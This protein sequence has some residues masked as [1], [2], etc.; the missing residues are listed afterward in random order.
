MLIWSRVCE[1]SRI[2]IVSPIQHLPSIVTI[3]VLGRYRLIVSNLAPTKNVSSWC[4]HLTIH[5]ARYINYLWNC[6]FRTIQP[7]RT[8]ANKLCYY[9]RELAC[10]RWT[11]RRRRR[12]QRQTG[13]N[14]PARVRWL[15][16]QFIFHW[17]RSWWVSWGCCETIFYHFL[18]TQTSLAQL[19][20]ECLRLREYLE[21]TIIVANVILYLWFPRGSTGDWRPLVT[22]KRTVN[23]NAVLI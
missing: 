5:L 22:A 15:L 6:I 23:G 13:R 21:R 9:I 2:A 12:R 20:A 19:E 10:R 3:P 14:A 4:V 16:L 7:S 11:R 8:E 18:L 1:K 17:Q